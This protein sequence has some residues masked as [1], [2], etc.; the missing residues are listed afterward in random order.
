LTGAERRR[1]LAAIAMGQAENLIGRVRL[2]L[3]RF[4]AGAAEIDV[5]TFTPAG[6]GSGAGGRAGL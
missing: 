3:G 2:A 1:L 4:P 6:F 5:R